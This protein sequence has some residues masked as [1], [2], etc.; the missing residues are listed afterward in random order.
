VWS[1]GRGL[2]S[3]WY[4]RRIPDGTLIVRCGIVPFCTETRSL[5]D[6]ELGLLDGQTQKLKALA[7]EYEKFR[8]RAQADLDL[9]K[10]EI[11]ALAEDDNSDMRAVENALKKYEAA[12][13]AMK[14]A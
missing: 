4:R 9:A 10:V 2:F 13:T 6:K 7:L 11:E 12:R 1:G 14:E 3:R 5:R 8:I